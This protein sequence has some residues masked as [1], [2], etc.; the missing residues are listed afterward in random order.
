M[1]DA[2][3]TPMGVCFPPLALSYQF[4]RYLILYDVI[5]SRAWYRDLYWKVHIDQHAF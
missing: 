2:L 1:W 3:M 5:H 4:G